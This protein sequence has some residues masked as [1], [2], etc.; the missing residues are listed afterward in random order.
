MDFQG[1]AM[2]KPR[3]IVND[4]PN[5]RLVSTFMEKDGEP[6]A[7]TA[8]HTLN[9]WEID[10]KTATALRCAIS[11]KLVGELLTIECPEIEARQYEVKLQSVADNLREYATIIPRSAI[12]GEPKTGSPG[13]LHPAILRIKDEY[14]DCRAVVSIGRVEGLMQAQLRHHDLEWI[15][16]TERLPGFLA[17][18][19]NYCQSSGAVNCAKIFA[20]ELVAS[21]KYRGHFDDLGRYSLISTDNSP[22]A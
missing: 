12:F 10:E 18:V 21:G 14:L 4:W 6:V 8:R 20:D 5:L 2:L 11:R 9:G 1:D 15:I 16:P 19:I 7:A 22:S 13:G 17:A 3:E